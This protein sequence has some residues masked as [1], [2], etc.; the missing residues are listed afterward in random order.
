[1]ED[2]IRLM[3]IDPGTSTLGVAILELDNQFNITSIITRCIDASKQ[4]TIF[5]ENANLEYRISVIGNEIEHDLNKYNPIGMAIELPFINPRRISSII[6]L[7]RLLGVLMDKS[8][9]NNPHRMIYKKSPSE[10]KNAVGAK[11]GADKDAVLEAILKIDEI[12]DKIDLESMTD[13]EV[14]AIAV[15][16]GFLKSLRACY[17][18]P[19]L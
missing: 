18:L 11:G 7:A 16:Y 1:M 2:K 17:V 3:G 6:P 15:T 9:N 10:V 5:R 12:S 8:I 19:I 4:K 13:H 14:D